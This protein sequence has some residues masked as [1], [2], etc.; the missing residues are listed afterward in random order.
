MRKEDRPK[1]KRIVEVQSVGFAPGAGF[2]ARGVLFL[3][4]ALRAVVYPKS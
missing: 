2:P 3:E 1:R 4:L